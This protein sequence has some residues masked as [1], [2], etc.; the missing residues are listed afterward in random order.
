MGLG[1]AD[2]GMMAPLNDDGEFAIIFGDSFTGGKFGEG[3]WFSPTGMVGEK[4][5]SGTIRVTRPLNDG[6]RAQPLIGYYSNIDMTTFIPSDVINLDGTLYMQGMWNKGLGNVT[7]TE[8]WKSTDNGKT[9]ESVWKGDQFHLKGMGNLLSWEKGP[10][11]YIYVVSSQF[12]RQDP[13]YLSRFR[14]WNIDDRD[15]WE[16]YDPKTKTWGSKATPILRS[17]VKAGEMNLRYIQGHW[18]LAMF[19]EGTAS[20]EVRVSKE[21]ATNWDSIK[22]AHVVVAG[23]GGWYAPQNAHNFTQLYG[24]YIVPGSTL[25]NLD[26]VVSQWNTGDNSRYMS[27]QFNVKGLDKFFG[28]ESAPVSH[29]TVGNQDV[30]EVAAENVTPRD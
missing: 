19:N 29:T 21:I 7:G 1:A 12:K 27:T 3:Q 24:G 2:L 4:D 22:P 9:W 25:D 16:S 26:L 14:P 23:R 28:I 18:V 20:I 6:I 15:L 5:S 8:I 17:Y 10:D 30:I 13:V 11:G